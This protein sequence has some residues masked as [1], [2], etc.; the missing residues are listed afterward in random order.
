M[1]IGDVTPD[2]SPTITATLC[3]NKLLQTLKRTIATNKQLIARATAL[4]VGCPGGQAAMN[5]Q[6]DA[7]QVEASALLDKMVA[8]INAHQE[9]GAADVVNP[10]L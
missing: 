7:N 10:L 6:L 8:L 1:P 3:A 2:I 9:S 5:T 4:V